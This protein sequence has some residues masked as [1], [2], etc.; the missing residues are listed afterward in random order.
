VRDYIHVVDI[1]EAHVLALEALDRVSGQAFNVGNGEGF[2]VSEVLETARRVTS[3]PI[4]AVEGPRRPG[5]PAVLVASSDK[6]RSILGWK[7]RHSSLE[8]IIQTAWNWKLRHPKGY[9]A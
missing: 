8:T 5:D 2:S 3:K 1:A 9:S 6:I 4:A 7:P